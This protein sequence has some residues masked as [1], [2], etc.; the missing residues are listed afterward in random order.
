MCSGMHDQCTCVGREGV[1]GVEGCAYLN[2]VH[3][4]FTD[5]LRLTFLHTS[6]G[7]EGSESSSERELL[8]RHVSHLDEELFVQ[9]AHLGHE[10]GSGLGRPIEGCHHFTY[11]S[12]HVDNVVPCLQE[13]RQGL[14]VVEKV[15]DVTA[16]GEVQAE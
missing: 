9:G 13:V 8:V 11:P 12:S 10:K 1:T 7:E 14:D 5:A 6:S 15:P 2:V 16:A 3:T 4:A